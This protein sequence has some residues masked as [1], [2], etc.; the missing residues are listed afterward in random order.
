[1]RARLHSLPQVRRAA[2]FTLVEL[3]ISIAIISVMT[4]YVAANYRTARQ[5]DEL[6]QGASLLASSVRRVQTMALAGEGVLTCS[7]G[8]T[9]KTCTKDADC[10]GGGTC[11]RSLPHGYGVHLSTA[12]AAAS[13]QTVIFADLNGDRAY[14]AGEEIRTDSISAGPFV[15]LT[16]LAPMTATKFLDIVLEPPKPTVWFN[17]SNALSVS[18]VVLTHSA[19]GKTRS[20]T[21]N[22]ITGQ[23]SADY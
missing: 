1:M 22:R 23:V 3:L 2:A 14:Q 15:G 18:T 20:V 5:S 17:A 6:R 4:G 10:N 13:R 16:S 12:T 8:G 9:V 11:V 19:T 21:I 7:G